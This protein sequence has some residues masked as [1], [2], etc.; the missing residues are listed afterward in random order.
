MTA[1]NCLI[2][3]IVFDGDDTLWLTQRIYWNARE[4]FLD[5]MVRMG[6][7]REASFNRFEAIDLA[8]IPT[9]KLSMHR[10]PHSMA[11]TYR[12]LTEAAGKPVD[13]AVESE[14]RAIG[15]SVFEIAP[16]LIE[17][18]REM[19]E[20]LR[21]ETD[22]RLILMTAGD[23]EVQ[24]RR[25]DTSGLRDLFHAIY[26]PELKKN[27]D[28]VAMLAKEELRPDE[29]WMIGNSIK[30]DI[31]PADA[32]GMRTAFLTTGSSWA[33]D[34]VATFPASTVRVESLPAFLAIVLPVH[35]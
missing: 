28:Y 2:R 32:A 24:N 4:Q 16:A 12:E 31:L 19:L 7:D 13:A 30:S 26:I 20:T 6:F 34:K 23:A 29:A 21:A 18:A 22:I 27:E 8:N 25:I 14:V 3:A 33:Y 5:V 17:G 9:R 15:Y 11:Q 10:F 35:A 1:T